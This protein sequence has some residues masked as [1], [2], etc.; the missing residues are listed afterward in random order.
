MM[1]VTLLYLKASST[2]LFYSNYV[3]Q[4]ND[5]LKN[6]RC[7]L[8]C[9]TYIFDCKVINRSG[10][11][12]TVMKIQMSLTRRLC[13]LPIEVNESLNQTF[14]SDKIAN[15]VEEINRSNEKGKHLWGSDCFV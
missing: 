7:F 4:Y 12:L 8:F 1:F 2:N 3:I 10:N 15:E 11:I 14:C 5:L 9:F 6:V 13:L